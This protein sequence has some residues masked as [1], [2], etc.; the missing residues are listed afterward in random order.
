MQYLTYFDRK[1]TLQFLLTQYS[2]QNRPCTVYIHGNKQTSKIPSSFLW[3]FPPTSDPARRPDRDPIIFT[4][5]HFFPAWEAVQSGVGAVINARTNKNK[6]RSSGRGIFS[7]G[8]MPLLHDR[9]SPR[10]T[11]SPPLAAFTGDAMTL[12][13][14]CL[15]CP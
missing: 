13:R 14:A 9:R 6:A 1:R 15:R 3:N 10:R 5:L 8:K 7:R 11:L 12:S 2:L 4:L